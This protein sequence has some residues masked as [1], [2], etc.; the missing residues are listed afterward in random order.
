MPNRKRKSS[1]SDSANV[2]VLPNEILVHIFQSVP[3]NHLVFYRVVCRNWR[4]LIETDVADEQF[5]RCWLYQESPKRTMRQ[6]ALVLRKTEML[7]AGALGVAYPA[8]RQKDVQPEEWTCVCLELAAHDH[9]ME[10][11]AV[12]ARNFRPRAP[13]KLY[14]QCFYAAYK[15]GAAK[16]AV[17]FFDRITEEKRTE[18]LGKEIDRSKQ[19][20]DKNSHS[21]LMLLSLMMN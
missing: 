10:L 6:S 11:E 3:L 4:R 1:S 20:P 14:E 21:I 19:N 13:R 9:R 12:I 7:K 8:R 15:K 2:P 17:A 16:V 18:F 5:K